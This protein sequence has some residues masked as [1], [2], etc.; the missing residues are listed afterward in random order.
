V[1]DIRGQLDKVGRGTTEGTTLYKL[2]AIVRHV[3]DDAC[4]GHY[5][6]DLRENCRWKIHDDSDVI[7]YPD[8]KPYLSE[9]VERNGYLFFYIQYSYSDLVH[10]VGNECELAEGISLEDMLLPYSY[11]PM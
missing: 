11:Q 10:E 4:E 9:D 7:N 6:C 5:V 1:Y 3:G 2:N 8:E